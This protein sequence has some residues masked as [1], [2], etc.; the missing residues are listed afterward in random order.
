MARANALVV[1][2]EDRPRSEPGEVL[3]ALPLLDD[4]QLATRFA[5]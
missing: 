4:A 1:V 2:P 3:H 5:L